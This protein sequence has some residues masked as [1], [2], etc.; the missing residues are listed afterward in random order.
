MN[1]ALRPRL[2]E[3]ER[4]ERPRRRAVTAEQVQVDRQPHRRDARQEPGS[5]QTH[6][7][8]RSRF[9][10]VSISLVT[11]GQVLA[12]RR[13]ER[14]I[15]PQQEVVEA[16]PAA[17]DAEIGDVRVHLAAILP[18]RVVGRDLHLLAGLEVH[19]HR[20]V[21]KRRRNLLRIED[22]KE[23]HLVAVKAQRLDGAHDVFGDS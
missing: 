5:K 11:D 4:A 21:A 23:D 9:D 18:L 20:G 8:L 15:G 17:A 22:V 7:R 1:R 16:G 6:L 3:H 13:V 12:Q 2:E 14:P 10:S 19:E